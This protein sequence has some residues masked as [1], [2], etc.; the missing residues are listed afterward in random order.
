MY[1]IQFADNSEFIGGEPDESLWDKIPEGK[2][3]ASLQYSF[4]G[5][6]MLFEG[7]EAYNH[8]VEHAVV[9]LNVSGQ[10]F[11]TTE[12][13]TQVILLGKWQNRVYEIIY[14]LIHKRVYQDVEFIGKE[15]ADKEGSQVGPL[16]KNT[17]A[18]TGWIKGQFDPAISP[19]ISTL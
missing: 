14:D 16:L 3:I 9:M 11:P 19:K 13:I 7:F 1:K 10:T 4:L 5:V 17:R 12:R 8:V 2:S 6:S 18:V 15:N